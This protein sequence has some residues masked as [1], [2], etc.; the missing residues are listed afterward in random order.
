MPSFK[1][2]LVV[3][4]SLSLG[5][6]LMTKGIS[7][8]HIE[9]IIES[10][11]AEKKIHSEKLLLTHKEHKVRK[12]FKHP[13]GKR[14]IDFIVEFISNAPQNTAYWKEINENSISLGFSR[15]S[16]NSALLRL[17]ESKIIERKRQ[18]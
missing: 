9:E 8:L 12:Q 13:S 11:R 5:S 2:T 17:I 1:V 3:E 14:V 4:D 15:S 16:I 10:K 7:L 18:G 6:I